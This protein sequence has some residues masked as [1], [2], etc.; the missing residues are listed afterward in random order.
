MTTPLSAEELLKHA[1]MMNNVVVGAIAQKYDIGELKKLATAKFRELLWLGAPSHSVPDIITAVFRT[2][3]VTD[4]G[5]RN[6]VNDF[7]AHYSTEIQRS[8]EQ[9]D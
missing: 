6:V 2:T 4:P 9:Y 8:P 3:S 7:C 1:K 5:L